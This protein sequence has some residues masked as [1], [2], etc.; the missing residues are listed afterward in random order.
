MKFTMKLLESPLE[1]VLLLIFV[2]YLIFPVKFPP[3]ISQF[4]NSP[5]GMILVVLLVAFT[6]YLNPI[7]GIL[8]VFVGYELL[9]RSMF[10]TK[11]ENKINNIQHANDSISQEQKDIQMQTMNP[12][13]EK[14]LEEWVVEKMSPIGQNTP[15]DG[16]VVTSFKPI[17][18]DIHE[19]SLVE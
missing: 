9:R 3:S 2:I 14:T 18:T 5:L 17:S 16:K 13:V 12:A 11:N 6:F 4:I 15:N 8:S 19:A 7:L 10:V 1:Y